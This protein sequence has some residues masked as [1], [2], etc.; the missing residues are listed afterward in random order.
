MNGQVAQSPGSMLEI[1]MHALNNSTADDFLDT[2]NLGVGNYE[3]AEYWQQMESFKDGM[4]AD[5]AMTDKIVRRAKLETKKRMVDAIYSESESRI[6]N[7]VS[8]PDP[9]DMS[10][11]QYLEEEMEEVWRNLGDPSRDYD[12]E[13]HQAWLVS[14]CTDIDPDWTPPHWRM[15]KARHEASRSKGAR[16]I[17][18]LFGRDPNPRQMRPMEDFE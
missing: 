3:D 12:R 14:A 18:N 15:L 1:Y 4:F 8:Y 9:G 5:A 7:G 10:K 6:L 13:E 11:R 17:D 2:I 16:L